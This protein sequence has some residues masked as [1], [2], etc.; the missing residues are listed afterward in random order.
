MLQLV[1][2]VRV[3]DAQSVQVTRAP[4]LELGHIASLLDLDRASVLTTRSQEELLDLF[5]SLWL[6]AIPSTG[7]RW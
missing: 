1:G 6:Q 5:N 3:C 4:N 2:L 7:Q